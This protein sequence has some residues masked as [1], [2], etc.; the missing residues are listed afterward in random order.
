MGFGLP[1]LEAGTTLLPSG[2]IGE[3][4]GDLSSRDLAREFCAAE[5]KDFCRKGFCLLE[6]FVKRCQRTN[7][8]QIELVMLV[9]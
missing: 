9:P 6:F 4:E 2:A 3:I 5:V 8:S 1:F 7:V